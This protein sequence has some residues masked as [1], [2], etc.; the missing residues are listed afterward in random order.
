MI[1]TIG[2]E[3]GS[4]GHDIARRLSQELNIKCYDKEIVDEAASN[5]QFSRE[6]L[7][8]Y[9][10]KRVSTF[11]ESSAQFIGMNEGFRLS[12]QAAS[13]QFSAIRA[14]ADKGDCIFVGR[15]ADYILRSRDDLVSV[16]ILG[17]LPARIKT[18]SERQHVSEE[19][20]KKIIRAVDKDRAS[21]Y[22]YYTDQLWGE[23]ENYDLCINSSDIGVEGTVNVIKAF[24]AAKKL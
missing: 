16:F 15:C 6:I 5:S 9:D 8:S 7:S 12:M 13:A 2:R 21:Y 24:I 14:I 11:I 19:Q 20:A 3:H 4:G 22:K 10:E 18:I 17:D 23:S 1:I